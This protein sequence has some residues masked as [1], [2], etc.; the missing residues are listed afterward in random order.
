MEIRGVNCGVTV[1]DDF[2]HHPTAI[3]ETLKALR[4]KFPSRR[5]WAVFEP[6]SNTTRRNV[7]QNELAAALGLA[8]CV[9]VAEVTRLDQLPP[10]QRLNPQQLI[11]DLVGKNLPA[12]YLPGTDAILLHLTAEARAGDVVCIFSN[13]GFG[14]IHQKL[15][16]A[17]FPGIMN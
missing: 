6:R 15:L 4:H 10:N 11:A 16:T 3:S 7:F 5:L 12:T 17:Q 13:G 9:V 2:G 8:D 1:V 14:G